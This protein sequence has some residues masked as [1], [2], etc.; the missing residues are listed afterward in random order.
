MPLHIFLYKFSQ[1]LMVH[2]TDPSGFSWWAWV[3]PAQ[4]VLDVHMLQRFLCLLRVTLPQIILHTSKTNAILGTTAR[5]V[6]FLVQLVLLFGSCVGV[7]GILF[8]FHLGAVWRYGQSKFHSLG[9]LIRQADGWPNSLVQRLQKPT[10]VLRHTK[11]NDS[12]MQWNRVSFQRNR[13]RRCQNKAILGGLT[14]YIITYQDT[15]CL[16]QRNAPNKEGQFLRLCAWPVMKQPLICG[17]FFLLPLR[18]TKSDS[19]LECPQFCQHLSL[20]YQVPNTSLLPKVDCFAGFFSPKCF[21]VF[22]GVVVSQRTS[23]GSA[24]VQEMM[25]YSFLVTVLVH[26]ST[27]FLPWHPI[28]LLAGLP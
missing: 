2:H 22:A 6:P 27:I 12:P 10:K 7:Q 20:H 18:R 26:A 1:I 19:L 24:F 8:A 13:I 4:I 3:R 17:Q 23:Q 25:R 11:I 28:F 21:T 16:L 5:V 14:L 9:A 15:V